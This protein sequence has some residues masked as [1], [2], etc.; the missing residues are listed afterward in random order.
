MSQRIIFNSGKRAAST[1]LGVGVAGAATIVTSYQQANASVT[2]LECWEHD[3][4]DFDLYISKPTIK[5]LPILLRK[6][7]KEG[8]E[9]WPWIW[10][11]PNN[12]GPHFVFVGVNEESLLQIQRLRDESNQNNILI[13]ASEENLKRVAM[14]RN[15]PDIYERCQCGLVVDRKV[16]LLNHEDKILMLDDQRVVAFDCLTL[17]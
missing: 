3:P 10:T 12:D 5:D 16:E 14:A 9:V 13:I 11:H 17:V 6:F 15:D 2:R 8:L 4:K 1:I 7:D